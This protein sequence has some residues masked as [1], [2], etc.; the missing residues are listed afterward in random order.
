MLQKIL[1]LEGNDT[2]SYLCQEMQSTGATQVKGTDLSNDTNYQ[3]SPKQKETA[4]VA[5]I[6]EKEIGSVVKKH[7][8]GRHRGSLG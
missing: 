6:N 5:N 2:G 8:T 4:Q 7:L 3:R 1:H